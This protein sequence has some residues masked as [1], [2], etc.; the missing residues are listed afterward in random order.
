MAA[1]GPPSGTEEQD[2]EGRK[3]HIKLLPRKCDI[4]K[5]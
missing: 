4:K 2:L 1:A 5:H 3:R